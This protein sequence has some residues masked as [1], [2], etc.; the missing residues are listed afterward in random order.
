VLFLIT[1]TAVLEQVMVLPAKPSRPG[2]LG[3]EGRGCPEDIGE[4]SMMR[5]CRA[6]HCSQVGHK[7]S[8]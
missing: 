5:V 4:T 2:L 1:I 3:G 7:L 6:S 8:A